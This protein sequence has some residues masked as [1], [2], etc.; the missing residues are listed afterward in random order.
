MRFQATLLKS[1]GMKLIVAGADYAYMW[2]VL[3]EQVT[4]ALPPYCEK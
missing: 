4:Q 1:V 3:A 2:R